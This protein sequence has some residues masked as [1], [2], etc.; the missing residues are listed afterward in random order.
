MWRVFE[1]TLEYEI[2]CTKSKGEGQKICW[3]TVPAVSNCVE[4]D[5]T[6]YAVLKRVEVEFW[7]GTCTCDPGTQRSVRRVNVEA[8]H[9][10]ARMLKREPTGGETMPNRREIWLFQGINVDE[11]AK[12][13]IGK[14]RP[15]I[16]TGSHSPGPPAPWA[17]MQKPRVRVERLLRSVKQQKE[18]DQGSLDIKLLYPTLCPSITSTHFTSKFRLNTFQCSVGG[19]VM[20]DAITYSQDCFIEKKF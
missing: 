6:S 18:S 17:S 1:L 2:I 9:F 10:G 12:I 4:H 15:T 13:L 11:M 5:G 14:T 19:A 8:A 7:C 3:H 20:L 16:S